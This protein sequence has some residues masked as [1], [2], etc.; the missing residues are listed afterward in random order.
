MAIINNAADGFPTDKVREAVTYISALKPH[1]GPMSAGTSII[2]SSTDT[3]P[4]EQF[5]AITST[6][7]D[8]NIYV[9]RAFALRS[10]VPDIAAAIEF[11]YQLHLRNMWDR[12]SWVPEDQW[13]DVVPMAMSLE[14]NSAIESE[15]RRI[16]PTGEASE[17]FLMKAGLNAAEVRKY[18]LGKMPDIRAIGGFFP[19]E[20]GLEPGMTAESYAKIIMDAMQSQ[21]IIDPDS[22]DSE[23]DD[24][25]EG[26]NDTQESPQEGQE[27]PQDGQNEEGEDS[28][29]GENDMAPETDSGDS[30]DDAPHDF[31]D[32]GQGEGSTDEDA[33][34]SEG[35]DDSQASVGSDADESDNDADDGQEGDDAS[36]HET[37]QEEGQES[38][39]STN[40]DD[41]SEG[42][43]SS[44]EDNSGDT[45]GG[46]SGDDHSGDPSSSN[47]ADSRAGDNSVDNDSD[48]GSGSDGDQNAGQGGDAGQLSDIEGTGAGTSPKQQGQGIPSSEGAGNVGG[49]TPK[50]ESMD[51]GTPIDQAREVMNR[52]D[53]RMDDPLSSMW[54]NSIHNPDDALDANPMKPDS[55]Q[56]GVDGN[57]E[58]QL[59]D[60]LDEVYEDLVASSKDPGVFSG[61][62][63]D[64]MLSAAVSNTKKKKADFASRQ[65]RV[66]VSAVQSARM[67]GA[68]D[69]S[70]AVRNPNQPMLGPIMPGTFDYSP[71]IY[72][73]QDV[74]G[75]M[76]G[77]YTIAAGKV[78]QDVTSD[79]ASSFNAKTL[80]IAVD[81]GIRAVSETSR[82]DD[83]KVWGAMYC[84]GGITD[85]SSIAVSVSLGKLVFEGRRYPEPDV[86][87]IL[88]DGKFKWPDRR[89]RVKTKWIVTTFK[90]SLK[91]LPEWLRKDEI[92]TID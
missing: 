38:D 18:Q 29:S 9:D 12:M 68:T 90:S 13:S 83:S 78:F 28:G 87:C 79:V 1:W 82:W 49:S 45:T 6:D 76:A 64:V 3:L 52:I 86:L 39:D 60:A 47:D 55:M 56:F 51:N 58:S 67:A 36:T 14:I 63:E 85:I 69:M 91:L 10:S 35:T 65:R 54:Q 53:E 70:L 43:G 37:G 41:N 89:P 15:Y 16:S 24:A 19:D 2:P 62:V 20:L 59:E 88:T 77:A 34:T 11:Q 44:D 4:G 25:D 46:D 30:E 66:T 21:D 81:F 74:S 27:A 92:V 73:I 7:K 61:D 48:Q 22:G 5:A 17:N 8:G 57:D 23:N 84:G 50:T 71:R 31:D 72:C 75:S 26:E 40:Q 33:D 42:Q 80:W 32:S